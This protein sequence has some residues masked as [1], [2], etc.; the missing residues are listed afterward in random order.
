MR[1]LDLAH[2]QVL[3]AASPAS[4]QTTVVSGQHAGHRQAKPPPLPEGGRQ[5]AGRD[6]QDAHLMDA[7]QI[8]SL[9]S[10]T[11]KDLT[12]P[13]TAIFALDNIQQPL[14]PPMCLASQSKAECTRHLWR[15][16]PL[17]PLPHISSTHSI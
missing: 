16:L 3:E 15:T 9:I 5:L 12:V 2:L 17:S 6:L 1:N 8:P 13:P 7:G 14:Q 10:Q 11:N 4:L